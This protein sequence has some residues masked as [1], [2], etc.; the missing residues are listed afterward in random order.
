MRNFKTSK[1]KK[2]VRISENHHKFLSK[3][4]G[5]KS[6]A[7]LLEYIINEFIKSDK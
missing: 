4:K 1:F 5:K 7:G 2:L 6:I 3:T